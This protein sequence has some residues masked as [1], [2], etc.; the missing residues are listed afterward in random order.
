MRKIN[1]TPQVRLW[2]LTIQLLPRQ[3]GGGETER[4][5][6]PCVFSFAAPVLGRL[7]SRYNSGNDSS[8]FSQNYNQRRCL[9]RATRCAYPACIYLSFPGMARIER[10]PLPAALYRTSGKVPRPPIDAPAPDPHQYSFFGRP[11]TGTRFSREFRHNPYKVPRPEVA[12]SA[13]SP[14]H[15]LSFSPPRLF[16]IC[17]KMAMSLGVGVCSAMVPVHEIRET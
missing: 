7:F 16:D 12:P 3:H 2:C 1:P 9:A 4:E 5:L 15:T 14:A 17:A 6:T 11:G 8:R 10:D 13:F